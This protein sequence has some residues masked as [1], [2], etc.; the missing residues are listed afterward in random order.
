VALVGL[1]VLFLAPPLQRLVED[2]M[3]DTGDSATTETVGSVLL[4]I[5]WLLIVT[6][7][8]V[9]LG[10]TTIWIVRVVRKR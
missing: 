7:F 2:N 8:V 4:L 10:G 6:S 9:V 3:F 1:V 5:L